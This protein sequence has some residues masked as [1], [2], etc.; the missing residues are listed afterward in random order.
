MEK[1][2]SH[3]Q[4]YLRGGGH[5]VIISAGHTSVIGLVERC[6]KCG[7]RYVPGAWTKV[8]VGWGANP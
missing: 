6:A 1:S 8:M 2:H 3:A 7:H 5:F 4:V